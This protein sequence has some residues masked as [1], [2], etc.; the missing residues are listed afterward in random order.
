MGQL[1][2]REK[3]EQRLPHAVVT[4]LMVWL[5]GKA[6]SLRHREW[7]DDGRSG[8][9]V[10]RVV[11]EC[12]DGGADQRVLKFFEAGGAARVANIRLASRDASPLHK[13][14]DFGKRHIAEVE[15]EAISLDEWSAVFL[16]IASGNLDASQQLGELFHKADFPDYCTAVVHSV[17]TEWNDNRVSRQSGRAAEILTGIMGRRRDHVLAW[18]VQH[19]FH[20]GPPLVAM[21]GWPRRLP[22]PFRMVTG[23]EGQEMVEDLLV[24]KA[25]GDLSGRN[26]I[27]PV[28]PEVD[29]ESYVLI[30]CD[31]YSDQAPLTRDP[32]HLLVAL[33]LDNF[34]QHKTKPQK[35]IASALVNPG[36]PSSADRFRKISVAIH[37]ARPPRVRE[38]WG[39]E[40]DRQCLLSLIGVG[41][42]HLG[43]ELR[44]R[45]LDEAKEWCFYVAALATEA[46]LQTR[47][48]QVRA[49]AAR[50]MPKLNIQVGITGLVNRRGERTK[51]WT[52]LTSGSGGVVTLGGT[53]GVGKTALVNNVLGGLA[54]ETGDW[55][56]SLIRAY[57]VNAATPLDVRT[58]VDCVTGEFE[59]EAPALP[60]R[61]GSPLVRLESELQR[62][63]DSRIVVSIDSAENLLDPDTEQVDRDLD[64]ALEMLATDREHRVTVLLVTQRKLF[65]PND[66]TWSARPSEIVESMPDEHYSAYLASMDQH[67][68]MDP[69]SLPE[70]SRQVLFERLAGNPRLAELALAAIIAANGEIDLAVLTEGLDEQDGDNIPVFLTNLLINRLSPVQRHVLEALAAFDTPVPEYVLRELVDDVSQA[71]FSPT[72]IHAALSTLAAGRVVHRTRSD[73]YFVPS[74]DCALI[75]S[76]KKTSV[77][78]T[79]YVLAAGRLTDLQN[80]DPRRPAD[81]RVHFAM[82]TALLRAGEHAAAYNIIELIDGVLREWNCAHL[83]RNQRKV[84]KGKLRDSHLEMANWNALGDIYTSDGRFPKASKAF[85]KA[86]SIANK[87]QDDV[88]KMRIQGNLAA[89]YWEKNDTHNALSYFEL[90]RDEAIRLRDPMVWMG[91]LEG[92]A[93]CHRRR[94]DYGTAVRNA[95]NALAIPRLADYPDTPRALSFATYRTVS[96]ALKL[97][98]WFAELERPDDAERLL[99]AAHEA[100]A[101]RSDDWLHAS[102]LDGRADV[103]FDRGDLESAESAASGAEDE[104]LRLRDPITLLQV[105]TT[106]CL[107]HLARNE[108]T[109]ARRVIERAHHYRRQGR[110]LIVLALHALADR[111]RRDRATA[112]KRFEHLYEEATGRI[113]HDERDFAA[114]DFKGLAICGLYLDDRREL[115][116]A[117]DAFRSAR[118]LTPPT[119][120]LVRRMRLILDKLD[121][122]GRR[123]NRLAPAI[124]ALGTR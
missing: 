62:L 20:D 72:V 112:D 84:V 93:D 8:E 68:R 43:R 63:G 11:R 89:M 40:W 55:A 103:F 113:R 61:G 51:L 22:N 115:E 10:A 12:D 91:A 94:G 6:F 66:R 42:V 99:G 44:T 95:E 92:I 102:C 27:L 82:L 81:L 50:T 26:V 104:A 48:R 9:P 56:P 4:A 17:L 90:T 41:L 21:K 109:K 39:S 117:V 36:E 101:E 67:G 52:S 98:R 121:E 77:R 30:D 80:L 122:S 124:A 35:E 3:W 79:L 71:M 46:Y 58:L 83:L 14:S 105:R 69:G 107:V 73:Q 75:L 65:S 111:Q 100:I 114:W 34:D 97:A 110:S 15:N 1:Y 74:D 31:R 49:T 123:P 45:D 37:E 33:A 87:R 78:A 23:A 25:H 118:D 24:G 38:S 32:M 108:V 76:G 53:R 13:P 57:E 28:R 5:D 96:I 120:A 16:H 119:P 106:L 47:P 60:R 18:A 116:E 86:L 29:A 19:G 2:D 64:E 59:P 85:G 7:F 54:E 70:R 88:S